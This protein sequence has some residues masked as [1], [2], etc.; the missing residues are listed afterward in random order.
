MGKI[1]L[2]LNVGT[3]YSATTPLQYTVTLD[4]RYVHNGHTKEHHYLYGLYAEKENVQDFR[5]IK[6]ELVMRGEDIVKKRNES[7]RLAY[8]EKMKSKDYREKHKPVSLSMWSKYIKFNG[9]DFFLKDLTLQR[10][11][12]YLLEHYSYIKDDFVGVGD[13]SNSLAK[14]PKKFISEISTKLLENFDVKVTMIFRDPVR[15][16]FSTANRASQ[17]IGHRDPVNLVKL[18]VKGTMEENVYYSTIYKNWSSVFGEENVHM[19]VMEEFSAGNVES[20]SK[21]LDFPIKKIHE[22]VYYPDMGVNAPRYDYLYDQW[23]SDIVMLDDDLYKYLYKRMSFV[24]DEFRQTFGYIPE[25]W[26]K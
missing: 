7:N 9:E 12:D 21:F 16:L 17:C 10:Y 5:E 3:C 19:I 24:Y 14:L 18:W 11:I 6:D 13:F 8:L 26:K 4:N 1:K 22:N 25:S 2:L 20:L 15:R 23:R